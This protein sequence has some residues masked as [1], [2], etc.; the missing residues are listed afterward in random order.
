MINETVIRCAGGSQEKKETRALSPRV[1]RT[2]ID[3]GHD[4]GRALCSRQRKYPC[5]SR[6]T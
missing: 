2:E 3:V 6:C 4:G 1:S 5:H